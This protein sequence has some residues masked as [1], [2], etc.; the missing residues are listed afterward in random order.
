MNKYLIVTEIESLKRERKYLLKRYKQ[1]QHYGYM[2]KAAEIQFKDEILQTSKMI[3]VLNKLL[4]EVKRPPIW[5]IFRVW[6]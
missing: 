5:N 4:N 2:S 3:D 6:K 1:V